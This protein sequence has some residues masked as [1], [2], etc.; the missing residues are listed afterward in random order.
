MRA[1]VVARIGGPEVLVVEDVP[2][3]EPGPGEVRVRI[4][5]IGVNFADTERRRAVYGP[6]PLPYIPG[7]E[8][9][10]EIDAL[11]DGVDAA[12]DG[13]RVAYWTTRSTGSYAPYAVVAARDL[14][15]FPRELPFAQMAALPQQGLTAWGVV[16][17][18]AAVRAGQTVLVHAAA[19]GVGQILVQLARRR[20]A[21]VLGTASSDAKLA[22][23]RALG[24]EALPYGDDLAAR[25]RALTGGRGVD[26]VLDSVGLATQAASMAVL[27]PLG[28]LVFY[29]D[30]SGAPAPIAIDDLYGRSLRVGAYGLDL[31]VDP[32]GWD[33]ARR[34]LAAAVCDGELTLTVAPPI[35]LSDA[36]EAHRALEAR[37]TIGKLIL[38]PDR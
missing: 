32:A 31:D 24:A 18:S 17:R 28:L 38:D 14:F 9:A 8:A 27:A 6:P 4:R 5:A 26:V 22:A 25:V 21:R 1:I 23:V 15:H 29:G 12:L 20:G 11:G 35:A 34:Q 10:G 16:H 7:H 33:E 2:V 3:P 37:A 30:A 19:G 13:A 36:A